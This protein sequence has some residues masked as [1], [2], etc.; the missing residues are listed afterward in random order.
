MS[1]KVAPSQKNLAPQSAKENNNNDRLSY[2][3]QKYLDS[4]KYNMLRSSQESGLIIKK[5]NPK[6]SVENSRLGILHHSSVSIGGGSS[7]DHSRDNIMMKARDSIDK[8]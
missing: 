2:L 8:I 1:T 4:Q 6:K 7:K 3:K 5:P